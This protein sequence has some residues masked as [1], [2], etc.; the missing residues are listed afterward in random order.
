MLTIS[1]NVSDQ[2]KQLT[3][4]RIQKTIFMKHRSMLTINRN[5][6]D[7]DIHL[8]SYTKNIFYQTLIHA[9]Y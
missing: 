5:V 7:Q 9:Y 4:L 3:S 8:T 1:R 6:S 2:D